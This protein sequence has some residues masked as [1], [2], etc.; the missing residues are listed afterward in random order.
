[1]IVVACF[2]FFF[3]CAHQN[4]KKGAHQNGKKGA[5]QNGKKMVIRMVKKCFD[6]GRYAMKLK[7]TAECL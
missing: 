6:G 3:A 7:I 5:H 4:D 1:M 2:R